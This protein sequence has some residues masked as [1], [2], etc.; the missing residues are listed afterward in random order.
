MRDVLAFI[1][2]KV[3]CS[4]ATNELTKERLVGATRQNQLNE[5]IPNKKPT[6]RPYGSLSRFF[7]IL[8]FRLASAYSHTAHIIVAHM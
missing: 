5:I 8:C 1:E 3:Y 4:N 6:P 2:A 7:S